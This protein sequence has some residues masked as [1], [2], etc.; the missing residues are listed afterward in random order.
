[1]E[2]KN[3]QKFIDYIRASVMTNY[4]LAQP[5]SLERI[6]QQL[7]ALYPYEHNSIAHAIDCMKDEIVG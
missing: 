4:M 1:M 3:M 2:D 7:E 5:L 6:Q